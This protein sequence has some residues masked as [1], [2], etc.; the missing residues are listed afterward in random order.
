MVAGDAPFVISE[1]APQGAFGRI[2]GGFTLPGGLIALLAG[3]VIYTSSFIAE[4]VRAGIQSVGRGQ[5][6]A[7]RSLGL[8]PTNVLRHVTFPQA[9]RVII[10]P[11]ISQFLNLTKNSSLAGAI[12][13]SDLT[14]VAK[15]MTQTAPAVSIFILIILAYLAMSLTYS[16]IGNLY[17]RHV[18]FTGS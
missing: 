14:N 7:A 5:T 11:L 15:T 17:N 6:E 18:R 12:G 1:P 10:P 3:L 9:L 4:I 16:L 2:A 13:Y 8:S